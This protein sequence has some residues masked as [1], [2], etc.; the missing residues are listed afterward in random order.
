M[1][2]H[3]HLKNSRKS[4]SCRENRPFL[5]RAHAPL[6]KRKKKGRDESD[7]LKLDICPVKTY[8]HND[9]LQLLQL[10]SVPTTI[11]FKQDWNYPIKRHLANYSFNVNEDII[12][13]HMRQVALRAPLRHNRSLGRADTSLKPRGF[14]FNENPRG[15]RLTR[16][17]WV[18]LARVFPRFYMDSGSPSHLYTRIADPRVLLS[19]DYHL[20]G[21]FA[22]T[23]CEAQLQIAG[24]DITRA[25]N[26]RSWTIAIY[27]RFILSGTEILSAYSFRYARYA[28]IKG[29]LFI[30]ST[31]P[32]AC[33]D[34]YEVSQEPRRTVRRK[35]WSCRIARVVRIRF[36]FSNRSP[37]SPSHTLF[38]FPFDLYLPVSLR[39]GRQNSFC[40]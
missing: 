36:L 16:G 30:R 26:V 14:R 33:A 6:I 35:L 10:L 28:D 15:R 32:A 24:R 3:I 1:T 27:R 17:T 2:K 25:R 37:A 4:H 39:P 21:R 9:S 40:S 31:E 18:R 20:N 11:L 12:A 8:R 34:R 29:S 22:S 13:P 38:L 5:M 23:C 7:S 19:N